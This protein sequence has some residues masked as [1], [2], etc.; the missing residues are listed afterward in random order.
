MSNIT[1]TIDDMAYG[2]DGVGR[3]EG[4]AVF[5][6]GTIPGE[7]VQVQLVDE[8]RRYSRARLVSV[9]EASELRVEPRCPYFGVCGGCHWQHIAYQA[10]LEYKAETVR[11]QIARLGGVQEPNVL[12]AIGLQPPWEYRNHVQLKIDADGALG[13]YAQGSH[14]VV[15]VESCPILHP[16][17]QEIRDSLDLSLPGLKEIALRTGTRTDDRMVILSG[18]RSLDPDVNVDLPVS[19][20]LL[21]GDAEPVVLA[22]SGRLRERLLDR[23]FSISAASFFQVNSTQAERLIT[24]VRDVLA[25]QSGERLLD[26]Y[27]GAGIFALSLAEDCSYVMAIESSPWAVGDAIRNR[28][29]GENVEIVEG[30]VGEALSELSPKFDAIVLDPPRSGCSEFTVR[31]LARCGASRI[32]YVSCDPATLA[33]DI[34][35]F[36]ALGYRLVSIQPVDMFPQTYH[37]E[38]VAH[39]VRS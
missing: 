10:Q 19:C 34:G 18:D 17:L 37:I 15:A 20:V 24:L 12:P 4:K 23:E 30:T 29:D 33:R 9:E 31:Q 11:Q 8:R 28:Q 36:G 35:R 39:L 22:G 25:L 6:P 14:D 5:V 2:G 32:A 7:T 1:L 26:A 27:C 21:I 13:Y 16:N 38:S 3:C